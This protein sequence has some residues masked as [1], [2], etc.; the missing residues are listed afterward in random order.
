MAPSAVSSSPVIPMATRSPS[1][2][3]G[4]RSHRS[5]GADIQN[6]HQIVDVDVR[7]VV[8]VE[9]DRWRNSLLAAY[10]FDLNA[11]CPIPRLS[12]RKKL[13]R[14]ATTEEIGKFAAEEI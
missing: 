3:A 6:I 5:A 7:I 14:G 11:A 12:F 1:I 10:N 2:P 9:D 13:R 4:R 8:A